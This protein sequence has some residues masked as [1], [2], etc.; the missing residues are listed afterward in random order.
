MKRVAWALIL[1]LAAVPSWAAKQITVGQLEDLLRS[2]QRDN[3]TDAEVA[4]AL[5]QVELSEELTAARMNGLVS[6]VRGPLSTEQIFVLEARSAD[7]IPPAEDLPATPLPDEATRHAILAKA[8][9]YVA[10]TYDQL[11]GLIASKTTLRFQ[12]NVEAVAASSGLSGSAKEVVTSPGFSNPASF[13]HFIN[14]TEEMAASDHGAEK[15]PAQIGKV[16]WG[17]NKM[18]ALEE[19]DPSLGVVFKEAQTAGGIHWL[20]WE[21][22]NGR[23]TAVYAFT[24]PSKKSHL[25][26]N[27]CCFPKINQT[28]VANFYT[29]T[30]AGMLGGMGASGGGVAGNFQTNTEWHNYKATA[31]YH[32]ELFIDPGSGIV[33]RMITEAELQPSEVVHQLNTRIDYGP[34][35]AGDKM[36]V[37]PVKTI[38][39]TQVVPNGDSGA[40]S[41]TTR[42]T[43]FTSE[44]K[45]YRLGGE[46]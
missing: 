8:A 26:L 24:V 12:D 38:I 16:Q 13:V 45:D 35:K 7:L 10:R 14:S 43:L 6:L 5:T 30:T 9:T 17:A 39:N 33:V 21:L 20:R 31:P 29:P 44:Y 41:Y 2:L 42:R 4:T 34:V 40:G 28:G 3:K 19:P 32:G 27:V 22:V 15:L 25:N 11:P 1:M 36:L 18:V 46:R 37:A 23:Q